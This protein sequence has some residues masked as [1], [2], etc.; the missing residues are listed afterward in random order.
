MLQQLAGTPAVLPNATVKCLP[1]SGIWGAWLGYLLDTLLL[2]AL[3]TS[4]LSK[5]AAEAFKPA[6]ISA[7]HGFRHGRIFCIVL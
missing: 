6:K 5:V 2:L 4:F 1:A 7:T 3:S